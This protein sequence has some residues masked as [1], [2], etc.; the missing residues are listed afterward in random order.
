MSKDGILEGT[1]TSGYILINLSTL[2]DNTCILHF[3]CCL[4]LNLLCYLYITMYLIHISQWVLLPVYSVIY[5]LISFVWS[6]YVVYYIWYIQ[7]KLCML[8]HEFLRRGKGN[9]CNCYFTFFAFCFLQNWCFIVCNFFIN[10]I[11]DPS[12]LRSTC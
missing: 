6:I 11:I 9:S 2:T 7:H 5:K 10:F 8:D 4:R 1:V 3:I 12:L